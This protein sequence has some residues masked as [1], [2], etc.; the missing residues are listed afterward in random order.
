MGHKVFVSYKYYD[1][2]NTREKIRERLG[3]EGQYYKGEKGFV[4]LEKA[5]ETIKT[6]LKGLIFPT[7]V[8]IVIISPMVRYSSWVDWEIRYSLRYTSSSGL[9]SYRNGILCI[10]QNQKDI[11]GNFNANWAFD[12]SGNYRREIFPQA[13]IDNMQTTFPSLNT[14]LRYYYNKPLLKDYC[15]VVCENTFFSNP[16]K[17]IEEAYSR[18][19]DDT[20]DVCVNKR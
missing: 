17:Y 20:F 2:V 13:I 14:Y 1:G 15:V 4:A 18:A 7:S 9:N 16:T 11:Y 6:Y 5:D 19:H 10:I 8:T 3:E 12:Y